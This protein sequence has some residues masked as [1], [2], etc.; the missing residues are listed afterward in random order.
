M[1]RADTQAIGFD[2]ESRALDWLL[3]QG[4][5]LVA[6]NYRC[7]LGEIDLVMMDR[8][9]LVFI[10]V[11]Y[12]KPGSKISAAESVG[13]AKQR[14]LVRAAARFIAHN[15]RFHDSTVRFDVVAIDGPS[16]GAPAWRWIRDAFRPE[17]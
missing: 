11:R 7:R 5:L 14:K 2:A 6:R 8:R 9:C 10:E 12:R 4:L 13:P 1:V 3:E 15:R 16:A 17:T